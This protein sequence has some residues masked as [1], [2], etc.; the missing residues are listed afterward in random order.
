M[1]HPSPNPNGR[2]D[3]GPAPRRVLY[4]MHGHPAIRPGGAEGYALELYKAMR[5][6]QRYRPTVL[7]RTGPPQTVD[8]LRD[9]T[10]L[11][12]VEDDPDQLLFATDASDYNLMLGALASPVP[13]T[14]YYPEVLRE[15]RPDVVHFHHT[16]Y[17]GYGMISATRRV[18][19]E[20][21][22]VYTL[23]E[24]LPIC[25]HHGQMVRTKEDELCHEASPLRCHEC[26]PNIRPHEF[27]LRKRYTQAHFDEVDMFVAPS[28]FLMQR[29]LDWG[30]PAERIINED[31]GRPPFAPLP[32]ADDPER[33]RNR[34]GFFGQFS[35]FK[36]VQVLLK[37]MAIVHER[38]PDVRLWLHGANLDLHSPEFQ[39]EFMELL[40]AAGESTILVGKYRPT[41]V[42]RLMSQTDWA[43]VPSLWWENSPLV[44]QEAFGHRRPVIC[45]NI[46]G[47]AEKVI[48]GH[49]GLH[50]RVGDPVS[51]AQTIERAATTPGLWQQLQGGIPKVHDMD[52]HVARLEDLYDRLVAARGYG[53]VAEGVGV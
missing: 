4:V 8:A 29:Y 46:G 35:N 51:L 31:Y 6:S 49:N 42:A 41:D 53:R 30:I 45:S 22:I 36:G 26:F 27:F 18:L 37:A 17:L 44:I 7:A 1:T 38:Q 16:L 10:R 13:V 43:I 9:G 20:A 21:A 23:H 28:R 47:M 12:L 52:V 25:H 2:A 3:G 19:P 34:L 15:L 50:F 11:S 33:P 14:K 24:Y 48:D 39:R 5:S 32:D 40:E